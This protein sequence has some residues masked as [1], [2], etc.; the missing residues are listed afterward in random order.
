MLRLGLS[1]DE[2][3]LLTA[4]ASREEHRSAARSLLR[5]GSGNFEQFLLHG[6]RD[7]FLGLGVNRLLKSQSFRL[8]GRG[9]GPVG[10]RVERDQALGGPPPVLGI[11]CGLEDGPK[12]VI[13]GLGNRIVAMVVAL[14]AADRQTQERR[15]DDLERVG[16]N[17]VRC[18]RKS[19]PPVDVPSAAMRKKP[20]AA[21]SSICFGT[22]SCSK[23]EGPVRRRPAARRR[24]GRADLSA[25]SERTT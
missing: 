25:L 18:E 24:T 17:L 13:V 21:S 7:M 11:E 12:A 9:P 1:V 22:S 6:R 2:L 10:V 15:A 8:D 4:V 3:L 19:A 23:A 5:S 20:V 14:G 16:H